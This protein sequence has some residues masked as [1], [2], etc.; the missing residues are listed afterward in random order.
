MNPKKILIAAGGTGGHILPALAVAKALQ[1][2]A[3]AVHWLGTPQGL[4][5]QLVP[6]SGIAMH[7]IEMRGVRGKGLR[8]WLVAPFKVLR[9]TV[10][11]MRIIWAL[12]PVAV[13]GFGGFVTVPAGL[14]AWLLRKPLILHEQNAVLGMSNRYLAYL[15]TGLF[16]AFPQTFP[17]KYQAVTCGN[18][19]R[20]DILGVQ[21]TPNT[22]LT[23]R[24]LIIGGS[25]GAATLNQIIP[26][27]L[28]ALA[29]KSVLEVWHAT[30][31]ADRAET[32]ARYAQY[33]IAA[34]VT[35]FIADMAAAYTWADLVICRA[36]ALT[37]A[38]LAAAGVPSILIPYPRAV[39]DHQTRNAAW[40]VD[41][42]AAMLM[43]EQ[44]LTPEKITALITRLMHDKNKLVAMGAAAKSVAMSAATQVMVDKSLLLIR[45]SD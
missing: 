8:T 39:D 33:Q 40:L 5:Q 44:T 19:V 42:G 29:D 13:F 24:L 25:Q 35:E 17:Q 18:P 31:K 37:V 41:A 36:G 11:A 3:L 45:I 27:A 6:P 12:K 28:A 38:E 14:A 2:H 20:A 15:A 43:P 16:Q 7:T 26:K 1:T 34:N 22:T 23:L 30:G 4:E 32:Q 21:K 9:A 10:Q